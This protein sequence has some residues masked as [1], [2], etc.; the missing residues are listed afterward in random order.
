MVRGVFGDRN[1]KFVGCH[2]PFSLLGF[3]DHQATADQLSELAALKRLEIL[4]LQ[5][6]KKIIGIAAINELPRLRR[7]TLVGCGHIGLETIEAKLATL[8]W[9]NTG[10]TT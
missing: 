6:C 4:S 8:E 10:A 1:T 5:Y 3:H 2:G 7:V 9:A